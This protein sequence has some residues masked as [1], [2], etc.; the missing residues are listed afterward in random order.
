MGAGGDLFFAGGLSR[1]LKNELPASIL[2]EMR[3]WGFWI[4]YCLISKIKST[5][6]MKFT[7]ISL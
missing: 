2:Y 1:I 7:R 3:D 4:G 5:V 6:N